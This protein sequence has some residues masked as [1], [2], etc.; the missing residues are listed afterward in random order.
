VIR[1]VL[2]T[3]IL[4]S[5]LLTPGGL[6]ARVFLMSITEP[7][8][9]LAISGDVFAEYEDVIRRPKLRRSETEIAGTLQTIRTRGR[10]VK[11]TGRIRAC[12]DPDDDIFLECAQ[13]VDA[14]YLVTGN[15]KDFPSNWGGLQIVTARAFLDAMV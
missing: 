7:E 12:S 9:E 3:N 10:W 4:V 14:H 11:P 8:I 15:T 6:P 1:V 2:D 5:A 13:A